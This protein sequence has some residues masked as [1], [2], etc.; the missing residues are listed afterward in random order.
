VTDGAREMQL[1]ALLRDT[2]RSI[3]VVSADGELA[4]AIRDRVD[5]TL[6]LVRD[7]RPDEALVAA[8]A[9]TP[10]PWLVVGDGDAAP[11]DFV[12]LLAQKPVIVL[13]HGKLAA[14][15][16]SH[17]RRLQ[18]A[19]DLLDAVGAAVR[20]TVGGMRLAAHAGVLMPDGTTVRSPSLQ[21]L[22]SNHPRGF[23]LGPHSFRSAAYS[24]SSHRV[25]W[26]P[27][28]RSDGQTALVPV[29]T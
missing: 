7:V 22:L 21:A 25:A 12:A 20:H 26:R 23:A 18:D 17:A 28:Q 27:A 6:A 19:S 11:A 15:L 2:M 5:P 29:Q 9:C 24:L 10:W 4:V 1:G 3:V 8:S 13:W 16:P 14:G